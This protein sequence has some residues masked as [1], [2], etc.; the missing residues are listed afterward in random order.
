M[1][2]CSARSFSVAFCV[3]NGF[4]AQAQMPFLRGDA[5]DDGRVSIADA[6]YIAQWLH[7]GGPPPPCVKAAD[8]NDD[9]LIRTSGAGG[10]SAGNDV[11]TI[12]ISISCGDLEHPAV[13]GCLSHDGIAVPRDAPGE[14]PTPDGLPCDSYTGRARPVDDPAAKLEILDATCPGGKNSL[15]VL[16]LRMSHSR[17]IGRFWGTFDGVGLFADAAGVSGSLSIDPR[18]SYSDYAVVNRGQVFFADLRDPR[19]LEPLL[20]GSDILVL[21]IYLLLEPGARAGVYPITLLEGELADAA[22][23]A[24]ILPTL[25]DGLLVVEEDVA[26]DALPERNGRTEFCRGSETLPPTGPE[27]MQVAYRMGLLPGE[28]GSRVTVPLWIHANAPI[29]A[30]SFA[31]S[32]QRDAVKLVRVLPREDGRTW[33]SFQADNTQRTDPAQPLDDVWGEAVFSAVD[34]AGFLPPRVLHHVLDFEFEV[35]PTAPDGL[36]RMELTFPS[37]GSE[38][39]DHVEPKTDFKAF[40]KW[41]GLDSITCTDAPRW[42]EGGILIGDTTTAFLRGDANADGVVS[43]ADAVLIGHG[44]QR[45]G[46]RIRCL[47]AA[48]ANDDGGANYGDAVRLFR[49]LIEPPSVETAIPAPFPEPGVDGTLDTILCDDYRVIPA[50]HTDDVVRLGTLSAVPG[51]SVLIPIYMSASRELQGYEVVIRYDPAVFT[52]TAGRIRLEGSPF[53][54]VSSDLGLNYVA[55]SLLPEHIVVV[56]TSNA[57]RPGTVPAGQ[58]IL[59]GRIGG[60]VSDT[61]QPGDEIVLEP[62]ASVAN[63]LPRDD[64]FRTEM[65]VMEDNRPVPRLPTLEAGFVRIVDGS[66]STFLRGDANGDLAVNISDAVFTLAYLFLGGTEPACPDAADADDSGKIELTDAVFTLSFLF[67]GGGARPLP[68]PYPDRGRDAQPDDLQPCR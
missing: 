26:P 54:A 11:R 24:A 6:Y 29:E 27:D 57:I 7:G 50:A 33:A 19:R 45:E 63:A 59:V 55:S 17:P 52:P 20:P 48:D 47:D 28:K 40:G 31:F 9:G 35:S 10:L 8:A 62:V 43:L 1:M 42:D 49:H 44:T 51:E 25:V 38:L 36:V 34:P 61:L 68:P 39:P 14:D 22:T 32:Y 4:V 16:K 37:A 23:G 66:E 21:K 56:F 30:F 67:S 5:N 53:E 41:L 64:S 58:D 15:A 46:P 3:L 60:Y 18:D 2:R 65:I 13:T 12:E